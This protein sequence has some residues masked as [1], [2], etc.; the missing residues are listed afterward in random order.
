M[1]SS[2]RR[3]LLALAATGAM[4]AA[5][6][7]VSHLENQEI[8]LEVP[9]ANIVLPA[10]STGTAVFAPCGGCA[11]KS[12]PATSSTGY[13]LKSTPVTLADLKA[14]IENQPGLILTVEYSVKTNELVRITADVNV[15]AP[16]RTP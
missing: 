8:A 6:A 11:I 7:Q 2:F 12:F 3:M 14:A 1:T 10:S 15:P 16:R 9:V 13:Y 4:S 5:L